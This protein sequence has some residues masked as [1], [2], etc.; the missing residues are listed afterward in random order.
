MAVLPDWTP[1]GPSCP[2][3]HQTTCARRTWT[4]RLPW[5]SVGLRCRTIQRALRSGAFAPPTSSR[6][7][8]FPREAARS[9]SRR[10]ACPSVPPIHHRAPGS[11]CGTEGAITRTP[12]HA[13]RTVAEAVGRYLRCD[14]RPRRCDHPSVELRPHERASAGCRDGAQESARPPR[15]RWTLAQLLQS[16]GLLPGRGLPREVPIAPRASRPGT[17]FHVK[18]RPASVARRQT[19]DAPRPVGVSERSGPL[20]TDRP[21]RAQP[22]PPSRSG[23]ARWPPFPPPTSV[24]WCALTALAQTDG[25]AVA[26]TQ[27]PIGRSSL[28]RPPPGSSH[29]ASPRRLRPLSWWLLSDLPPNP[30]RVAQRAARRQT[31][32]LPPEARAG[33]RASRLPRARRGSL[34]RRGYDTGG[35]R[36]GVPRNPDCR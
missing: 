14:E 22:G 20:P 24:A 19:H 11:T 15:M 35:S 30:E 25:A 5:P 10:R 8:P 27:P 23:R 33:V 36:V 2:E 13:A 17:P 29:S 9:S 3:N 18:R 34:T 31:C 12:K 21:G 7:A 16:N 1:R 32:E 26:R 6:P 28:A 4:P